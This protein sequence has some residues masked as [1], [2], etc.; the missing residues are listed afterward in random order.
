MENVVAYL[1]DFNAWTVL[2]RVLLAALAG[3]LVG[4]ERAAHGRA[5]GLRTH[6]AVSV[7]AALTVM[8]G[9]YA[10]NVLGVETADPLRVAAQVVSGVGFLGAGTILLRRGGSQ[11]QGL[12]TAAG[13]WAVATIGLAMGLGFYE[14]ALIATFMLVL[15]LSL[16]SRLEFFMNRKRQRAFVY[17]EIQNV[18]L[19]KQ[20]LE[21][22]RKDFDAVETQVT[23]PRS[24]TSPYVGVEALIRIPQKSTM[25]KELARIEKLDG[26]IF[27]LLNH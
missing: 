24:G 21:T 13:L 27:T 2:L 4:F 25:E 15:T 6:M 1:R 18:A 19:T 14:G 10:V 17:L 9:L 3:A 23:P 22:L 26:V 5:A 12:T 11:I 20:M 8:V 16:V 7:G